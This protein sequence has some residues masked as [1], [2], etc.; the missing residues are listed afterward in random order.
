ME[1]NVWDFGGQEIYHAT[2]RFYLTNHALFILVWSARLGYEAGKIYQWLETI[3]ALAPD[4]PVSIAATHCKDRGAGL[5]KG[6][7]LSKYPGKVHFFEADN[8][9][10]QGI[11]QL[12]EEMET[13]FTLLKDYVGMLPGKTPGETG[14]DLV[15]RSPGEIERA[16]GWG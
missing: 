2:H 16:S 9:N 6:D 7:I 15:E 12:L 10:K 4:S 14:L 3:A 5:P 1:L 11:P 13:S 8:E